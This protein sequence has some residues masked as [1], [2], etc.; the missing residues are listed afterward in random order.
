[1][2]AMEAAYSEKQEIVSPLEEDSDLS[3]RVSAHL[4]DFDFRIVAAAG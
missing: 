1:M 3:C 2:V 4:L